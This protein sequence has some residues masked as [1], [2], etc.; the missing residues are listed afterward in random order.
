MQLYEI[1]IY[2]ALTNI[3]DTLGNFYLSEALT[4]VQFKIKLML[5]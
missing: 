1:D 5:L 2:N 4:V 3:N